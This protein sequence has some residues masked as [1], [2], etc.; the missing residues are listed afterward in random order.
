MLVT[1]KIWIAAAIVAS[2]A[3]LT[4]TANAQVADQAGRHGPAQGMAT[5]SVTKY[6]RLERTLQRA[7][8]E[9]DRDALVGMLDADF[10]QRS[11]AREDA[12]PLDGWLNE[13]LGKTRPNGRVRDLFVTETDDL[14]IVSFLLDTERP[15]KGKPV[16]YFIVDV[17]RQSTDKLQARYRDIPANPPRAPNRPDGRE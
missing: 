12:L 7:V 5:R 11:A 13:E 2:A 16:T 17:W 9:H 3:L 14:A 1:R 10:V 15:D 6:L 4:G 8:A